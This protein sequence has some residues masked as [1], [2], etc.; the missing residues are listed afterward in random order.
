MPP[1]HGT[2]TKLSSDLSALLSQATHQ[3]VVL[4]AGDKMITAHRSLLSVRSPVFKAMFQ[5]N[6]AE[7]GSWCVRIQDMDAETMETMI[8]YIYTGKV[9]NLRTISAENL[10]IAAYEYHLEELKEICEQYISTVLTD[11]NAFHKLKLAETYNCRLLEFQCLYYILRRFSHI[12]IPDNFVNLSFT[13]GTIDL[14]KTVMR[15]R[16][17]YPSGRFYD[18]LRTIL[19]VFD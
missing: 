12:V 14:L 13:E 10:M 7:T 19:H 6:M 5:T 8:G 2:Q 4:K 11:E 1:D 3:D 18:L 9:P 16:I 15:I 17:E